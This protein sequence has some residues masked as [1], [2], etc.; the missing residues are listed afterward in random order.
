MFFSNV[1]IV[2]VFN[3]GNLRL[4]HPLPEIRSAIKGSKKNTILPSL[5]RLLFQGGVGSGPHSHDMSAMVLF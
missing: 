2:G 4:P 1:L 5:G 3:D